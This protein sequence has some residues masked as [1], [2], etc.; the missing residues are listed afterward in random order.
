LGRQIVIT[1]RAALF[2][3]AVEQVG[4]QLRLDFRRAHVRPASERANSSNDPAVELDGQ[5]VTSG[6]EGEFRRPDI[7]GVALDGVGAEGVFIRVR[8]IAVRWR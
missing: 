1:N 7:E 4:D 3:Q 5:G 2:A 6:K 8:A